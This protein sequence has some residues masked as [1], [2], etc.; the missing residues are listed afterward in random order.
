MRAV[1]IRAVALETY[2]TNFRKSQQKGVCA[3]KTHHIYS[4]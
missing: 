4:I 3:Y 2:W 1:A